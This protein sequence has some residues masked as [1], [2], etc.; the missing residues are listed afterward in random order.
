MQFIEFKKFSSLDSTPAEYQPGSILSLAISLVGNLF[1][2]GLFLS[3]ALF[4]GNSA[5]FIFDTGALIFMVELFGISA[6]MFSLGFHGTGTQALTFGN[7]SRAL[8]IGILLFFMGA[9]ALIYNAWFLFLYFL[10]SLI[11]KFYG[12][13]SAPDP[14]KIGMVVIL[15]IFT[16]F[17]TSIA[18]PL[19]KILMPLPQEIFEYSPAGGGDGLWLSAPQTIIA[20]GVLYYFLLA[21]IELEFYLVPRNQKRRYFVIAFLYGFGVFV[22]RLML[23]FLAWQ[24]WRSKQ[25]DKS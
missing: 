8:Y 17:L 6:S 10:V 18:A 12:R 11:S 4:P 2:A 3:A 7:Q 25:R 23:K 21:A 20:W 19:L 9:M 14:Q 13:K 5:K 15:L 24:S 22:W 16:L 1:L